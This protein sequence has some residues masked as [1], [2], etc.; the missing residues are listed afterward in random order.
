M[1]AT[2]QTW[3][4]SK[5]LHVVFGL[6]AVAM[7]AATVW[8]LAVDH[9]R[10]WKD[11]Q[12]KFQ[13]IE[14]WTTEAR[15][16]QESSD[17]YH[18]QLK[19]AREAFEAAQRE[20]PP[21]S[22]IDDFE[23]AVRDANKDEGPANLD[24]VDN[25][26]KA[27]AKAEPDERPAL[28]KQL[29]S[30][31]QGYVNQAKFRED[32]L[33]SEK[34]FFAADLDVARSE[35]ELGV[36][37]QMPHDELEQK[38]EKVTEMMKKVDEATVKV[39][40]AAAY[41]KQL[42]AILAKINGPEAEKQ[43]A[44]EDLQGKLVQLEKQLYERENHVMKDIIGLP[45]IDAFSPKKLDQIWLPKLTINNN[46]R[47][48]ARFDRCTNCHQGI[49]K[50]A[51]GSAIEP[52]YVPEQSIE[53][54]LQ[55]PAAAPEVMADASAASTATK[56]EL[57]IRALKDAYGLQLA[58]EGLLDPAEATISV[59]RPEMAGAKANLQVGDTITSVNGAKVYDR[60][61]V[62]G[63]LLETVQWGQ[64]LKLV[65]RRGLPSPYSSHPR[66]D[67]FVGSLSPHKMADIG[68]TICHDGQGSSTSFKWASHTPNDPAEANRWS[69]ERG[70]FENH[71]WIFP[72]YPKRFSESLCLKCHHEVTELQP[73]EKFPDPPAPKLVEG[74][75]LIQDFGCF[76]CH[77]INGFDGPNRRIGPDLR[78]EPN[79]TAAAEA[80]LNGGGLD[81]QQQAWAHDL[82]REPS[83][84]SARHALQA[85]LKNAEKLPGSDPTV[86][87]K[88]VALLDD[89]ETPGKYRKVGPSLRHV[90]S[91]VDFSFLYSWI[92]KPSDFRPTTKMPQFFG[93]YNHLGEAGLHDA[94]RYEPLEI[95]GAAEYLLAKSQPF[96][97]AEPPK[98]VS[99]KA[100]AERGKVAFEV[101]CLAC[102]QHNDF[103][104][105]KMTQGPDLTRIAAKFSA[106]SN[107]NGPKWLYSWL[108]NP[109]NYHPRTLMPNMILQPVKN[110]EGKLVDPAADIAE[111]LLTGEQDWMPK[112]VPAREL[113]AAE[114]ESLDALALESL[115]AALNSERLAKN[116]LETGIPEDLRNEIKGDEIELV[117]PMSTEKKLQY[118]GRRAI[119]KYG[120][121]GCHDIPGFEDV[122]PI[123]TGLADWARKTPDKLAFEQIVEYM[124]KGHGAPGP[125]IHNETGEPKDVTD[126]EIEEAEADTHG[127]AHFNFLNMDS[128]TGY[129][130]QRLVNHQREGFIW[131]KLREP[132]SYD[133]EKTQNKTYNERLRMPQFTAFNDAQREAII[134]FVLGLVAEPPASQYVFKGD[135]RRRA[136][137]E[138][139]Q[140]V[141]KFNCTGCHALEM[142]KWKLAYEPSDFP[143]PPALED[144]PFLKAQ[145]SPQQVKASLVTDPQGK[146][147][148]TLSGMP[149]FNDEGKPLKID[150]EGSPIE[151][152]DTTT[153]A[154]Y[155]FVLW[156][157]A[158]LNGQPRQ[159]GLQNILVPESRIVKRY[160]QLG[161]YLPRWAYATV[162][163]EERK[164]NPNAKA[165]EA[166]GW[167]PPPL[168]GEGRK[169]QTAWLHDFL[170]D[171][172]EIRP[173]AVLRMPKFN[174]SPSDAT[175]LVNY[176]AAVDQVDY[177]Y[178][179]DPRT[180]ESYLAAQNK[181]HPNRLG[182]ALNI[183]TD[184]NFCIK[185]HLLGDFAP[186]G[187]DR[188]KA[189]QL[190]EVYERL[191][192]DYV[193]DWI[194]NPKRILPYTGM[195]V[196]VPF[197]K[198]VDQKLYKGDSDQQLNA[199]VDLLLNYDRFME[200]KTSIK[201]LIKSP[202]AAAAENASAEARAAN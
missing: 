61:A 136:I 24:A 65:V 198:P 47:D 137:I 49:D 92:R 196:N 28:R 11:Y 107:P 72:M 130:M 197:D 164:V 140:V 55:T 95:R 162:V 109:S 91:K 36:G 90:A 54:A 74:F 178:N 67:L 89:V 85:S 199:L 38:Q 15:I 69:Q 59:V 179:F 154:F 10:E 2:E 189:P 14:A 87:K 31:L 173:A 13:G 4:D 188:A 104:A 7:L 171:P 68:C 32:G 97:F 8:M 120:C 160:P 99:E 141:E 43:K 5:L 93:L 3:R 83:N 194:A 27:L 151:A 139:Q 186:G 161:G 113:T 77:E 152:D 143:D 44:I 78:T 132:R 58:A 145:F 176:F 56:E 157:N 39:Q 40:N 123:G 23:D 62:Y 22:L 17:V 128:D 50:T 182:D 187:S 110:A 124:L 149:A 94:E 108:Q 192:P 201:P 150:E 117:G 9:R 100:S 45:I 103:P 177:P 144:Y 33:A 155:S 165:E 147:H 148:A 119:S 81:D 134:T 180:R 41:R 190:G 96:Q 146:L 84:E 133:Y 21:G 60:R 118:V 142:E 101:R 19:E 52:G 138:G 111:F 82:V 153:P 80:L 159:A 1:P 174:M 102:H 156:Q 46:F 71:H 175:K 26:Y 168:V 158:L 86:T 35:F 200:S 34:K 79:Y 16:S 57:Y 20:V 126:A 166:W 195:P 127:H 76:G 75:Q 25:A 115:K 105:G 191:R 6:S 106:K 181:Q 169:V 70:W 122:K 135:A 37:N 116:Y 183:V 129:F 51:P 114:T 163:S 202:P 66:L 125:L 172:H 185:C 30:L 63:Y 184:N 121:S 98:S 12:R 18:T 29:T 64:P 42:E 88:L 53:I 193:L 112:D 131:Q 73:S 170:L 167:L 48:V